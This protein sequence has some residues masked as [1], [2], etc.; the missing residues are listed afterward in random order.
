M[1]LIV[2]KFIPF[3]PTFSL[4]RPTAMTNLKYTRIIIIVNIHKTTTLFIPF[5]YF[6]A[7][8][9]PLNHSSSSSPT[10]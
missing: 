1:T 6:I 9:R 10:L 4:I 2:L 3:P 5:R 7:I 8:P